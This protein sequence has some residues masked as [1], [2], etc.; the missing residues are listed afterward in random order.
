MFERMNAFNITE[1]KQYLQS[2]GIAVGLDLTKI[3]FD[4]VTKMKYEL[5]RYDVKKD[6]GFYFKHC[7]SERA[8]LFM[9]NDCV[10]VPKV[11]FI[12]SN[13][14]SLTCEHCS[15]L[16]PKF[17]IPWEIGVNEAIFFIDNFL[18]GT[19]EVLHFNLV[20]GEPFLYKDL[21]AILEHLNKNDKIKHVSLFTN[22]TI[23]PNENVLKA[24]K[25]NKG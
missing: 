1:A 8:K 24:L 11:I 19:D 18:R 16:M 22:G 12:L 14:C 9:S 13:K 21:P 17:K 25:S 15:M 2:R 6:I 5:M 7:F 23:L 10:I 3:D 4:F 20:G